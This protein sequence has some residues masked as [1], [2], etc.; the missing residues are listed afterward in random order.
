MCNISRHLVCLAPLITD[1]NQL[2][3]TSGKCPTPSCDYMIVWPILLEEL[4][5]KDGVKTIKVSVPRLEKQ[6]AKI[7]LDEQANL[8][9]VQP[10]NA[11]Q[12]SSEWRSQT[13]SSVARKVLNSISEENKTSFTQFSLSPSFNR[14]YSS[15]ISENNCPDISDFEMLPLAERLKKRLHN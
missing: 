11:A 10:V 6:M 9:K 12:F 2:I 13:Q 1:E 7:S 5:K 4:K 3:P 15:S 14:K 8:K